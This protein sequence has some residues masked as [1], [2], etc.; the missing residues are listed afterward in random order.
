DLNRLSNQAVQA[1]GPA[2][3]ASFAQAAPSQVVA[4]ALL[5]GT[6]IEA[7]TGQAP[8]AAPVAT[9]QDN[10]AVE[11]M[12]Q[13]RIAFDYTHLGSRGADFFAAMVAQELA[14]VAPPGLRR[15]LVL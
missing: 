7:S 4:T 8:A 1:L 13:A 14:R 9:P 3:S 2:V 15:N 11:P 6:T 10:A 5:T 12:G